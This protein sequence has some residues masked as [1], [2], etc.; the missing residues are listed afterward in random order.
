MKKNA[1][2]NLKLKTNDNERFNNLHD[3]ERFKHTTN[4]KASGNKDRRRLQH[5]DPAKKWWIVI[6]SMQIKSSK[7]KEKL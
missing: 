1:C 3:D 2:K 6:H 5:R 7:M 4:T